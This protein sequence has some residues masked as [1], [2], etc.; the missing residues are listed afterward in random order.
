M[1]FAEVVAAPAHLTLYGAMAGTVPIY[2]VAM[3]VSD[4]PFYRLMADDLANPLK[5]G[6]TGQR[7]VTGW[8]VPRC[9][10]RVVRTRLSRSEPNREAMG[11]RGR[12]SPGRVHHRDAGCSDQRLD[13]KTQVPSGEPERELVVRGGLRDRIPPGLVASLECAGDLREMLTTVATSPAIIA[14]KAK[15]VTRRRFASRSGQKRSRTGHSTGRLRCHEGNRV[16]SHRQLHR[17]LCSDACCPLR[18]RVCGRQLRR[19]RAHDR[20]RDAQSR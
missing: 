17:P 15:A 16:T 3:V 9:C 12:C 18:A 1:L 13:T 5:R 14:T 2:L 10:G 20:P 6:V 8:G 4:G 7:L 11:D 19:S